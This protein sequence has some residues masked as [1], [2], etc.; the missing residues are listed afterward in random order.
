M[1]T[2]FGVDVTGGSLEE[3]LQHFQHTAY[4]PSFRN[5][6]RSGQRG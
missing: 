1:C 6:R 3:D 5:D 4:I 2:T